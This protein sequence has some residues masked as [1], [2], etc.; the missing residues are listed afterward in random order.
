MALASP[1]ELDSGVVA[2]FGSATRVLTLAPLA[3]ATAPMTAY[4][5]ATVSRLQRIKV[6]AELRRLALSGVTREVKLGKN[7]SGWELVDPDIR[8]L[9]QR[10][11]RITWYG[12]WQRG[13]AERAKR[14]DAMIA[15]AG[16]WDPSRYG[17]PNRSA[18]SNPEE[19]VRPPEK[20]RVLA[21]MGLKTSS[22]AKQKSG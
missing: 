5:I 10:R 6:Y 8:Q 1:I 16:R 9:L 19:F 22:R 2:T 3:S 21:R 20:D 18:V 17:P 14:A 13:T 15:E 12:D 4:R 7:R 11:V